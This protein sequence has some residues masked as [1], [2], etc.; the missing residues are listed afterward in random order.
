ML[1]RDGAAE[2]EFRTIVGRA[3]Y[4][5]FLAARDKAKISSKS[6]LVHEV[7]AK[8]FVDNGQSAIGNRLNALRVVRNDAD[9]DM[10]KKVG[11]KEAEDALKY[12]LKILG[13]LG[14]AR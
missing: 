9:Y 7:T 12:S 1:K 2:R 14:L 4:G 8:Y 11:R 10:A 3:Y 6:A 13:D 5:A